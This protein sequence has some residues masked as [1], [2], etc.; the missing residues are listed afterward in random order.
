MEEENFDTTTLNAISELCVV[1]KCNVADVG[2][3]RCIY[4]VDRWRGR[5]S[6][7]ESR[8]CKCG[9]RRNVCVPK[10]CVDGLDYVDCPFFDR[11]L[12][13]LIG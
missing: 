1:L 8:N 2:L 6:V 12:T 7:T 3:C 11:C 13:F 4:F 10:G 5:E 9:F